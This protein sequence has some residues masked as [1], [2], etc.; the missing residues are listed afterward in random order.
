MEY[1]TFANN[2]YTVGFP[3]VHT[4]HVLH[5]QLLH[6]SIGIGSNCPR[7]SGTVPDLLTLSPVP[8]GSNTVLLFVLEA[9]SGI[10]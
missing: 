1:M 7:I 8:E 9:Q 4:M 2:S 6:Y 10:V 3:V 5:K